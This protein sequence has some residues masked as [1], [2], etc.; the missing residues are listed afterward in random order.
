MAKLITTSVVRGGEQGESHGGAHIID[1]EKQD[2]RQVMD[3]ITPDIDGQGRAWD[4]GLRGIAIDGE[5]VYFVSSEVLFAFT[6]DLELIGSWRNS[7]LQ[8]ADEMCIYKRCLYITSAGY[9][10]ILA[11]ELD[12]KKFFWALH[13]DLDRFNFNASIYDPMGDEGPLLLNKLHLNNV[14]ANDNGMYISGMKSGGMLHFNGEAVNMSVTLPEGTHN[15]QPYRDG[16][17]FNDSEAAAVR[18]ASRSGEEDRALKVPQYDPADID[19]EG[20]DESSDA[21][22]GFARGL[23]LINDRIVAAG[24]SPSTISI[25]D[26]QESKTLLSVNL[27]MDIRSAIHGLEVWP[28]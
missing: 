7:Y 27:S 14:H 6:P 17:L 13:V 26:L 16:V 21:R 19:N 20:I 18:Y 22:Q 4:R 25:H 8:H 15:A 24:S 12:D 28:F 2:G 1:F 5:T 11:F 9:D 3:C 23:C 10:S